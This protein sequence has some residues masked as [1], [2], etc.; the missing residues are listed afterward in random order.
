M[1]LISLE[2]ITSSILYKHYKDIDIHN[3]TTVVIRRTI[4]GFLYWTYC[5]LILYY[6][7]Y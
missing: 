5:I 1:F 3:S 7:T 4:N 6:T 2:D